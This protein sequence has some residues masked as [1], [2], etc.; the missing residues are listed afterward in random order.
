MSV[1]V[2]LYC[3]DDCMKNQHDFESLPDDIMI[4]KRLL[5][6]IG[7]VYIEDELLYGVIQDDD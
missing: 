1:I 2:S 7:S 4:C 5:D 6:H 3:K